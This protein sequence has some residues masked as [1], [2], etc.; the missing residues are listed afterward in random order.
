MIF[1]LLGTFLSWSAWGLVIWNMDP[2]EAGIAGFVLFYL[3]LLMSLVGTMTLLGV[4]YRVMLLKRHALV[5]REVRIAFR[6]AILIS[7]VGIISLILS[8]LGFLRWWAI[9]AMIL[10]VCGLE[11]L[12]LIGE[13]SRR[14]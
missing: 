5:M 6:H 12:F 11:Y 9:T 3:T 14:V 13:E 4:V 1:M 8:G 10:L 7:L 2:T